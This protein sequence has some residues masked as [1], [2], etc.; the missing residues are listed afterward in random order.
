MTTSALSSLFAHS[1]DRDPHFSH[2]G[3]RGT[4]VLLAHDATLLIHQYALFKPN[5]QSKT[6][7]IPVNHEGKLTGRYKIVTKDCFFV[8][9]ALE[10]LEIW[11]KELCRHKAPQRTG[12]EVHR[13]RKHYITN[14][15]LLRFKAPQSEF[16]N[17][18]LLVLSIFASSLS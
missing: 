1:L 15:L 14:P 11:H 2:P 18:E 16:D 13:A 8:E 17:V 10:D 6:S 7:I 9:V 12:C 5:F 4:E 3:L